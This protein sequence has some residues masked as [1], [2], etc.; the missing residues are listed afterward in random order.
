MIRKNN[1]LANKSTNLRINVNEKKI[2]LFQKL[3]NLFKK[4]QVNE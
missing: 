2:K 1:I 4:F 3:L